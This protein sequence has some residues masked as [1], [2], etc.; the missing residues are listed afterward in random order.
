MQFPPDEV[1]IDPDAVV[2]RFLRYAALAPVAAGGCGLELVLRESDQLEPW[3][4]EEPLQER[5]ARLLGSEHHPHREYSPGTAPGPSWL[6]LL[7]PGLVAGLQASIVEG[8]HLLALSGGV[9]LRAAVHP[10]LG[11]DPSDV[12]TLPSVA[13]KL[14]PLRGDAAADHY[15]RFDELQDSGYDNAP[16]AP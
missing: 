2:A 16:P 5:R 6:T 15:G 11:A 9:C 8:P 14:R 7:G 1:A 3:W 4:H 12:G 10:P 13:R